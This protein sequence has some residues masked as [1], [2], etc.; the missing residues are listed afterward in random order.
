MKYKFI[1]KSTSF[2]FWQL[3]MYYTYSSLAGLCN[4]IFAVAMILMTTKF[5]GDVNSFVK[6][7]LVFACCLFPIIQPLGIY[8]RAKR[9][10]AIAQ[11]IDI[12]F[13]EVGIHVKSNNQ[14]SDLEWKSI[15]KVSKKHNILVIFSTT[16]HGFLLTNR[17][18]G[19]QKEELYNY[20]ISKMNK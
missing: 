6:M 8:I 5:W 4:V 20:V 14:R 12:E 18:L 10:S 7:L 1:Y 3:S 9:Q 11:S 19:K 2:D 13:D 17:V 16:T 15:N